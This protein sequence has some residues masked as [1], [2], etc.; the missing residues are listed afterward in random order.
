M[1][2]GRPYRGGIIVRRSSNRITVVNELDMED[3]LKGVVPAEMPATFPLEA[4]KAQAVA[5]RT[6]AR[7]R[8]AQ[9]GFS[10]LLPTVSDQVY[11]G[12]AAESDTS[13]NAVTSTTGEVLA[14]GA[15]V[16]PAYFHSTC[17]GMSERA[18]HVWPP[19]SRQPRDRTWL[20]ADRYIFVPSP[21]GFCMASPHFV[22]TSR[23][24]VSQMAAVIRKLTGRRGL[25][26]LGISAR[27]E[28]WRAANFEAVFHVRKDDT[29]T[30][31]INGPRLRMAV[32]PNRLKSL[33]CDVRVEE[34]DFVFTGNGWGHGVGLCQWGAHGMASAGF[35]YRAILRKYYPGAVLDGPARIEDWPSAPLEPA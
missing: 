10:G 35:D 6:Y 32:G 16:I 24:P 18:S 33:L 17:G 31:L 25:L 2:E 7:Y 14:L 23:I 27:N 21:D 29:A 5:A 1:V 3:Y 13:N 30:M 26:S 4:L 19:T 12:V 8:A 34:N 22:W 9:S 11:R 28:S 15:D 20:D